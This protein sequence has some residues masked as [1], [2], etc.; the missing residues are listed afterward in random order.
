MNT[1]ANDLKKSN[2]FVLTE[3]GGLAHKTTN[4]SVY[5]MFAVGGA[6]RDRSEED[7]ILL[8][9]KAYEENPNLAVKC[10]FYLRDCRG[11]Q[12]E[13]RFFRTVYH[14]LANSYPDVA[15]KNLAYLPEFGRWDDLFVLFDTPLEKEMLRFVKNQFVLDLSCQTPSLLGKWMPSENASA[16]ATIA[17]ARK[18]IKFFGITSKEY[19]KNL[20]SLREKIKIIETLMSQNRWEEIEFDKIPS[21]AGLKYRNAFA[22]RDIIAQRFEEFIK[23]EDTKVNAD[24]LY[25]Y[26]IVANAVKG[27]RRSYEGYTFNSISDTERMTLEKY[28]NNLP[29]YF[30]G[31]SSN[32]MCVIDTS[33][34]MTGENADSP[35]NV[36]IALGMYCA[37]RLNGDF[38]NQFISFSS[39]PK[40]IEIEGIDFVDKVRRIFSQ[41]LC[42]DTNLEATFD[43][44][45][46]TAM[47]PSVNKEDIPDTIVI[48]SDMEIN[49]MSNCNSTDE[50]KTM[51]EQQREK[52]AAAGLKMPKLV[53]WNVQARGC[54]K[55]LDDG[56]N[57]SY[58]SGASPVIFEQV[59]KGITGYDLMLDKLNS[60]RYEVISA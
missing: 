7:C 14:W 59:L 18:F 10:L 36:A 56:P 32:I 44:L 57:I 45:L 11:G 53:Y 1:F 15:R 20:V 6:Y 24:T 39:C 12:G 16:K 49:Y 30:N 40:Y 34:S 13:R 21:K 37:E 29:D 41:N 60:D 43:L 33:G 17:N 4:S 35:M 27:Y 5:D 22:R 46:E 55:F 47:K 19:R 51:M 8:F 26:E 3:N 48:I 9:K 2:N 23:R 42:S 38:H 54:N 28:W 50:V 31:K 58:V 25:P 52:W